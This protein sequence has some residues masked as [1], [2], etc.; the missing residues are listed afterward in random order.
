MGKVNYH[1]YFYYDEDSTTC[2]RWKVERRPARAPNGKCPINPGDVAGTRN[3]CYKSG[4]PKGTYVRINK[5]THQI[6]RVIWELFNGPIP[7]GYVVDHLDGNPWNNNIKN[8]MCKTLQ[9]NA[10]N[11]CKSKNN[12]T[13]VVGVYLVIAPR[14][15][16]PGVPY[17]DARVE[18]SGK[19]KSKAFSILK[20]GKDEALR[21]ATE[22]RMAS[23]QTLIEQGA[24]YTDRHING[25][26]YEEV[27]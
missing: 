26:E 8:L 22:W 9:D 16:A 7:E 20:H 13:G 24:G 27:S 11:R 17:Y 1:D 4:R 6:H 15:N 25:A 23:L 12:S 2:L 3:R 10:R 21:L 19:Y 18:L 14:R 5:K